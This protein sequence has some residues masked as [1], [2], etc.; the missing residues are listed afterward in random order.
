[1]T[2]AS[3]DIYASTKLNFT[4]VPGEANIGAQTMEYLR[5]GVSVGF[6]ARKDN[7][8]FSLDYKIQHGWRST[9][10]SVFGT[11]CYEFL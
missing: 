6:I 10:Q 9:E 8:N 7:F 11:F 5:Y 1:M 2:P 4:G 3:G